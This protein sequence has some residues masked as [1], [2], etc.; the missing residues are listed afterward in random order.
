MTHPD[1]ETR[2]QNLERSVGR[3]RLT[4]VLLGLGLIGF[5]GLAANA[6][7][8][9]TPEIRAHKI[10]IVDDQGREAMHLMTGPHGGVLNVLNTEGFP[11]VR[12]GASDKGGKLALSDAK[13]QQ[14]VQLTSEDTGG[15]MT[16]SDKKGQ[17]S[18]MKATAGSHTEK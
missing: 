17:K 3:Y 2:L 9:V 8:Q 13:G 16:L 10:I 18:L 15:E 11:V 12:A 4:S 5:A 6:P 14:Y 1:I 7:Q